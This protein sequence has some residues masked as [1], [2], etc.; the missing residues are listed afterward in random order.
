M[1]TMKIGH[2]HLKVRDL[3]RSIAFYER[4]LKLH[5]TENVE[6]HYV[7][8][9]GGSFHHEIALQRV[10]ED[11]AAP[12]PHGV[13][14]YHVAFEVPSAR[15]FAEAYQALVDGG[16]RVATV[17]HYISWAMY[18]DD[19][20]GN[21]LE[22]YWDTRNEPDGRKLWHGDNQPLPSEKILMALRA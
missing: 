1:Y 13:G 9:T 16:V 18:F 17:D 10:A 6:D 7:F 22:V 3:Q 15:D 11:A 8:M 20:D 2:A 21:G 4:Y 14:L 5:V 19:P 12:D